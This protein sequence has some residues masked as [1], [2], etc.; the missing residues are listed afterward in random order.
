MSGRTLR[1]KNFDAGDYQEKVYDLARTN[2][3]LLAKTVTQV[4]RKKNASD[5]DLDKADSATIMLG[6][7]IVMFGSIAGM[8]YWDGRMKAKRDAMIAAWEAQGNAV[9]G[10]PK[11]WDVAGKTDPEMLIGPIP[12]TAIV[13]AVASVVAVA[14]AIGRG[15]NK[16][17]GFWETAATWTAVGT[18]S[19][20]VG[21]LTQSKG[22]CQVEEGIQSGRIPLAA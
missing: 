6:A 10:C 3:A 13:P 4:A 1:Q 21:Q 8:L 17:P 18:F 22:F 7:A 14:T 15:K 2:P 12:K 9:E 11:P 19:V 16:M 20:L 5:G